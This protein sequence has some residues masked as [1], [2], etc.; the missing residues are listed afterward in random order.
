MSLAIAIVEDSNVNL[1][2]D[3]QISFPEKTGKKSCFG[4]KVF[5]IDKD[6]AI[7]YSGIA[8]HIAHGRI[9]AIYEQGNKKDLY[10][11]AKQI[12]LSFD[13]K[14]DFLLAKTG[15]NPSIAKVS[16]GYISFKINKGLF[17]IGDSDAARFVLDKKTYNTFELQYKLE[18]AIK[19]P[20]FT[21]VGGHAIVA[22]DTIN[23][24]KFLPY[25]NLISPRYSL[26]GTDWKTVDF[27]TSQTGGFGY[28][29]IVPVEA[30]INGWGIFYF[31]GF[32]GEYW[33]VD[34]EKNV[35]ELLRAHAKNVED[36]IKIIQDDIGIE[37]EYCG[38]LDV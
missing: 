23:G 25:M 30:G 20:Q 4:L 29:T 21:T 2:A 5:F 28:T 27:G 12:F 6:I 31:Q 33:H 8:G 16:D 34:L 32:F 36:F 24:F 18:N 7:A 19:D 9:N 35:Y 37:L 11:L 13:D 22:K 1:I 38:S 15:E 10:T 3:T 17:W 14:V 26:E